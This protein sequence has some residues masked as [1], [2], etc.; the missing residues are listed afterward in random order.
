[1]LLLLHVPLLHLLRLLLVPLLHLVALG[2]AVA[3]LFR[4]LVFL[5]LLLLQ[6]LP[7]LFLLGK[8]LVL[9]LLVFLVA[10]RIAGVGRRE[11]LE[12]WKV[13]RMDWRT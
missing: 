11:R 3:P 8:H 4:S 12:F 13:V 5:L 1:M 6:L 10:I 7:L 9:L 2:L